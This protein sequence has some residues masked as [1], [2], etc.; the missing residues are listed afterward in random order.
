MHE[1]ITKALIQKY[2]LEGMEIR[3]IP[4]S[5]LKE[6]WINFYSKKERFCFIYPAIGGN[7][8]KCKYFKYEA[9]RKDNSKTE[10]FVHK[11]SVHIET[12]LGDRVSIETDDSVDFREKSPRDILLA[13][14]KFPK[15]DAK[16]YDGMKIF[17]TLIEDIG[18]QKNQ[19]INASTP[20][21]I[22]I[23]SKKIE[24]LYCRKRGYE[25]IC[26]WGMFSYKEKRFE[27]K[28]EKDGGFSLKLLGTQEEI[29]NMD[30]KKLIKKA[31]ERL[32]IFRQEIEQFNS[33]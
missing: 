8:A 26:T 5:E 18:I 15:S 9:L 11:D 1:E 13:I 6:V 14:Q 27:F 29:E 7:R 10:I 3:I 33:N 28:E 17:E 21:A 4:S 32:E 23:A 12:Y 30:V 25:L 2:S 19:I 22:R 31:R 20:R 16:T 24:N